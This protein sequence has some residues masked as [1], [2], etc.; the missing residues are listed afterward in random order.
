MAFL[1]GRKVAYSDDASEE[2][3]ARK[4]KKLVIRSMLAKE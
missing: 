4:E 2:E 3:G 1:G